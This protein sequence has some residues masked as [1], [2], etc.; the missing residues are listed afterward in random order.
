MRPTVN[1]HFISLDD[2]CILNMPCKRLLFCFY[3]TTSNVYIDCGSVN[4]EEGLTCSACIVPNV[5]LSELRTGIKIVD[6]RTLF[7]MQ[8]MHKFVT[9]W[10][11]LCMLCSTYLLSEEYDDTEGIKVKK[12]AVSW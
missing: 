9:V 7:W 5:I 6:E 1:K 8:I 3:S 10:V 12:R 2:N 11:Q 4:S